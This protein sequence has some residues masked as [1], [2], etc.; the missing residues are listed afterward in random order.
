MNT[1]WRD[2][3]EQS[4]GLMGGKPVL[5]GTRLAVEHV[6][7]EL[8]AGMTREEVIE[9]YPSLRPEHIQAALLFAADVVRRRG[10][11]FLSPAKGT[12]ARSPFDV[13][14]VKTAA[15]T[16]DILDA[17]RESRKGQA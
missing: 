12:E 11:V 7:K 15:S 6:L 4:P 9:N 3:I 1:Q 16:S 13:P 2:L 10:S 8:G 17:V 14:G 5:K